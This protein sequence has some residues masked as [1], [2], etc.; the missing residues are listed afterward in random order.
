MPRNW[1][2]LAFVLSAALGACGSP[3]PGMSG[4]VAETCRETCVGGGHSG[5]SCSADVCICRTVMSEGQTVMGISS[6]GVVS[7]RSEHFDLALSI[8][9]VG[10]SAAMPEGR[11]DLGVQA[12]G[13]A[14]A[15]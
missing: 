4:C 13:A 6:G 5:G 2:V 1:S 10:A 9:P 15:R 14:Q 11:V 8:A 12:Q 3:P 7:R